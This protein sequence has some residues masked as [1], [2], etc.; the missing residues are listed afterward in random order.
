MIVDGRQ[1]SETL[2]GIRE[3]HRNRYSFAA[4]MGKGMANTIADIGAGIGYG[5]W[6]LADAGY[7]VYSY[8]INQTA[9]EYGEK[10]YSHPNLQ[11]TICD[12]M[13]VTV[14]ADMMIAFEIVEHVTEPER[15]LTNDCRRLVMSVPNENV[16]P[17]S[18]NKHPEH[19]RHYTPD[20]VI[21][22]LHNCGWPHVRI[23]YQAGKHG[24][25]AI[26]ISEPEGR[27][28]IAVASK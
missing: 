20:E 19:V 2:A 10:H 9:T 27:T 7:I 22:M 5:S 28:I 13:N 14:D 12:V 17:F 26:V 11:R 6:M 18:K 15:F 21:E 8:E 4:W 16:I 25:D 3:D 23:F 1:V 24:D